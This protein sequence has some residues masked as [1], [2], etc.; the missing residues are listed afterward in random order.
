MTDDELLKRQEE[1]AKEMGS[2]K[3]AL[4]NQQIQDL[5][6]ELEKRK[7]ASPNEV[8]FKEGIDALKNLLNAAT[9]KLKSSTKKKK[10]TPISTGK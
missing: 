2:D 7:S 1:L 4:K 9:E 6:D 10:T 3:S 8:A 5:I